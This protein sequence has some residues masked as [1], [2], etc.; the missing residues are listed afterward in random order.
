MKL[1]VRCKGEREERERGEA[2]SDG[3]RGWRVQKMCR[4]MI[5]NDEAATVNTK[6]N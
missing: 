6:L 4:R 2:C 5:A 1:V 3:E